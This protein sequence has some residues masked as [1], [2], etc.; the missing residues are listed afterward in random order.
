MRRSKSIKLPPTT[1]KNIN[2]TTNSAQ[3]SSDSPLR[4][5]EKSMEINYE[6][7]HDGI[8]YNIDA[9]KLASPAEGKIIEQILIHH[10]PRDWRDIEALAQIHTKSARETL[11]GAI[12]DPDPHVRVAVT[13][14]APNLV[15]NQE[16]NQSLI[17]ALQS[18]KIFSGLSQTLD[19][20]EEYHPAK[21]KE[22]L[23]KG[24]LSR[25]GDV[26]VLFA[27]MLFYIYGKAAE[28]F[29]MEQRPFFLRFNTEN[30]EERAQAFIELCKQ[31]NINPE[32]YLARTT[33]K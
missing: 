30:R 9:I 1:S 20:I 16:R 32:K 27:A 4:C 21:I 11:T 12:K 10:S 17:K 23:L 26:A 7:W 19:D 22:A 3:S 31:L 14:F 6:K 13:R 15:T 28:P 18:A 8:G 33:Q 2:H 29:D 5:F 24:L 25:E